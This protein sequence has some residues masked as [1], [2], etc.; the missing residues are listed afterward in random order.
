MSILR[1]DTNPRDLDLSQGLSEVLYR[2]GMQAHIDMMPTGEFRLA[3]LGHDSPML[4]YMLTDK[5]VEALMGWGSTYVNKRAYETFTSIVR[6]DFDMPD[7]FVSASNA[8]GRVAMGLHG[9]RIGDGEYGYRSRG[10]PFF[11]L[12]SRFSRGWSGD[13]VSWAPR[14]QGMHLRRFGNHV[15]DPYGGPVVAERPDGRLKPGEARSGGYGFYYKGRQQA[16]DIDVL[17]VKENFKFEELK[18]AD[19][20]PKGQAVPLTDAL[21]GSLYFNDGFQECLRTHGVAIDSKNKTLTIQSGATKLDY[22]YNLKPEE[23]KKLTALQNKGKGGVSLE[24]RLDIIN[25]VIGGDFE[26]KLT[27][28]MLES[29]DIVQLEMFPE[30]R[31]EKESA[32][33]AQEQQMLEQQRLAE[34]RARIQEK[35]DEERAKTQ[36][37]S[38]RIKADPN[39]INGREIQEIMG[40]RGWFQPVEHGREMYVGEIRVDKTTPYDREVLTIKKEDNTKLL[41]NANDLLAYLKESE[42]TTVQQKIDGLLNK[43]DEYR[44]QLQ[45]QKELRA[46]IDKT[47]SD[48]EK[49]KET[50]GQDWDIKVA[51]MEE[52]LR[53]YKAKLQDDKALDVKIDNIDGQILHLNSLGDVDMKEAIALSEERRDLLRKEVENAERL[54]AVNDKTKCVMSALINGRWVEHAIS[55]KDYVKFVELDDKHRLKMFDKV[56]NEVQIKS[57]NGE[58][59]YSD[60]LYMSQDGQTVLHQEGDGIAHATS[61]N[62][63]G[64]ALQEFNE[65]KSFYHERAHGREVEVGNIQVDPAENGKYKM[66]AVINGQSVS[67]EITQKQYDKFLAVDDYQRMRLFAKIFDEVDIKTRPGEKTNIGAAILAALT[68]AGEVLTEPMYVGHGPR[69]EIYESR[70]GTIYSKPGVVSPAD[71][72]AANFRSQEASLGDAPEEGLRRGI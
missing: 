54:L 44:Q 24:T 40:N 63:N 37:E 70:M 31:A 57:A 49:M 51:N 47:T 50:K 25:K 39:A 2:N 4:T 46:D 11:G 56:F 69:P 1:R 64:A 9:Y 14:H 23:V 43:Q 16:A 29:K 72:A 41:A 68:V 34:E 62:V 17:D 67:H 48:I 21:N 33:M 18:G 58:S 52:L 19:R 45:E 30:K 7:N 28:D 22:E 20:P 6:K 15:Y 42:G 10:I 32:Y 13:F 65:K 36:R 8:F 12:F 26:T 55:E 35:I 66:T 61:N 60:D 59:M 38:D 71:V 3:V 5:Q 27:R 53:Q